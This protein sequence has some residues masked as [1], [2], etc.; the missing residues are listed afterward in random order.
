MEFTE[1]AAIWRQSEAEF[2][3]AKSG[4]VDFAWFFAR[5]E[6]NFILRKIFLPMVP[7]LGI[8]RALPIPIQCN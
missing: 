8:V 7:G 3:F 6:K 5:A 1:N 2:G 4:C